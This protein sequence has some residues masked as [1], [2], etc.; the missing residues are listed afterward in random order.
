MGVLDGKAIVI[1]GAGRG[2]GAA[3]AVHAADEG[4]SVLINDID[5]STAELTTGAI[6]ERG[7]AAV[8]AVADITDWAAAADLIGRCL[9][10]F[11]SIDGLVNNAGLEAIGDPE[12]ITE[13]DIRRLFEVNVIGTMF[14]GVHAIRAMLAGQGGSIVNA[15]S[16]AQAALGHQSVYAATKGA[17][18]SL[19]YTWAM[20][21]AGRGVRVNAVSPMAATQMGRDA[22]AR[23]QAR[24]GGPATAGPGSATLPTPEA[25][26]PVVTFLLSDMA[27]EVNGQVVRID[28][29]RLSLMTH[30]GVLHPPLVR[31]Q[32]SLD[33]V[34]E[35]FRTDLSARQLPLGVH[36]FEQRLRDYPLPY[37][38]S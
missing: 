31:A 7:G 27:A 1:T 22:W 25:N 37:R 12:E 3:Y 38:N 36:A 16:G 10:E 13:E 24:R 32:W 26:A 4:A 6:R 35:A 15:T 9:D 18:S 11:G 29:G 19:T 23:Y 20:D 34:A 28:H 17:V 30:P 2:L 8:A 14:C 21:L 33:E 5:A